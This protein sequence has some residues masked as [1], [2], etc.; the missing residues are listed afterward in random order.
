MR[1]SMRE[2]LRKNYWRLKGYVESD[3]HAP[4][5]KPDIQSNQ[6]IALMEIVEELEK[7]F[8]AFKVDVEAGRYK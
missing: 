4:E 7:R 8:D 3:Y 6:V 2:R 5:V 1:E